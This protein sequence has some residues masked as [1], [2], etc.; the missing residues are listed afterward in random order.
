VKP[1]TVRI[2]YHTIRTFTVLSALAIS[3]M[4]PIGVL[5]EQTED[6]TT[7]PIPI[8]ELNYDQKE[9]SAPLVLDGSMSYD[10]DTYEPLR[11]VW[12][13]MR[14][15]TDAPI[16]Y[17]E[18]DSSAT[19]NI[20]VAGTYKIRL[21][22]YDTSMN[23]AT[24]EREI[25]IIDTEPVISASIG[26][27]T[28]GENSRIGIP[29]DEGPW[30]IMA[31]ATNS[32]D[33]GGISCNWYLDQNIWLEGCVHTI[34]E[35][36]LGEYEHRDVILEVMDDDGSQKTLKF[37]FRKDDNSSDRTFLYLSLSII[38]LFFVTFLYRRRRTNFNIPKWK[39]NTVE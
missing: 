1:I 15:P 22:V 6:D 38:S 26:D 11:Y 33:E 7:P 18:N 9:Q 17:D 23:S 36:P 16:T 30:M 34:Q 32:G 21:T 35:W 10:P 37:Q 25:R 13:A 29:E 39:P 3:I 8:F 19:M 4:M 5:G 31:L 28:I 20:N 12:T 14:G 24:L 2:C 27:F